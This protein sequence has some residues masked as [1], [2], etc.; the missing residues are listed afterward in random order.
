[1]VAWKYISFVEYFFVIG[2]TGNICS[3]FILYIL[4]YGI[5]N[6]LMMAETFSILNVYMPNE[7]ECI[8]D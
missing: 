7:S 3:A 1:M 5:R 8:N 2:I 4:S 6:K